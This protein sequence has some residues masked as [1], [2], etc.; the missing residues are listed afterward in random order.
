MNRKT[1][2]GKRKIFEQTKEFEQGHVNSRLR[3]GLNMTLTNS[4][5][6][7]WKDENYITQKYNREI[8]KNQIKN[9]K[10]TLCK[11][12]TKSSKN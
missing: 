4:D 7:Q 2:V 8:T 6:E 5:C 3:K 9:K 11:E 12:V 1:S 10:G